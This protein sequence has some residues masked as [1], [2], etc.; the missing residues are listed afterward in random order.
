MQETM[1]LQ[2]FAEGTAA[3]AAAAGPGVDAGTGEATGKAADAGLPGQKTGKHAPALENPADR[4]ATGKENAAAPNAAAKE[5]GPENGEQGTRPS[6]EELIAGAYK[7][8]FDARVQ[9]ILDRRFKAAKM[10]EAEREKVSPIVGMLAAKYGQDPE[11]L[12][13]A[14]LQKAMEED[15][16]L[17]EQEALERGLPVEA[18]KAMRKTEVENRTLRRTLE[19]QERERKAQESYQQL[20]RQAEKVREVYPSFNLAAEMQNPDF[21]RLVANGVDART[22]FEVIHK[23]EII[24]AA[25]QLS[26]QRTEE[27]LSKAIQANSERPSENGVSSAAAAVVKIDPRTFSKQQRVD[28]RRRVARGEKIYL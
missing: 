1:D 3:S 20:C 7:A 10:L 26:A 14:A 15:D 2:L 12:D 5:N 8:D 22:A 4:P 18:V 6:F 13:Y 27:K 11:H 23:D 24:P 28:L 17:Y 25:M 21:G 9:K 16:A 19:E